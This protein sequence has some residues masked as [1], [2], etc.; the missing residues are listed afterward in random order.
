MVSWGS[1]QCLQSANSVG[2]RELRDI[3]IH[4]QSPLDWRQEIRFA[5]LCVGHFVPST[6]SVSFQ[7][8][9]LS[10]LHCEIWYKCHWVGQY[11]RSFD[12][13]ERAKAWR[14]WGF[15]EKS[16]KQKIIFSS[17][18]FVV[19]GWIQYAAWWQMECTEFETVFG[20]N[21][22]QRGHRQ[23]VRKHFVV[24]C[25]FVARRGAR[26]GCR[27]TL[28]R[29]L[30]LRYHH[31]QHTEAMAGRSERIAIADIDHGQRSHSKIQ[32]NW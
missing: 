12:E 8:G 20:G 22:G 23:I 6:Q 1:Q 7:I 19:A 18:L 2:Q 30:R 28:F 9:F 32:I 24:D 16:G 4:W 15:N 26:H 3:A 13:C 25:A 29:M 5:T 31:W 11:V 14:K 10:I 27:S 21:A 17:F